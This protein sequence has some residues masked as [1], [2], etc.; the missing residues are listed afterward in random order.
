MPGPLPDLCCHLLQH[1][2]FN[3]RLPDP[4]SKQAGGLR[5]RPP[6]IDARGE[7]VAADAEPGA[8]LPRLSARLPLPRRMRLRHLK[9]TVISPSS[10]P[11]GDST[12]AN[13]S[14]RVENFSPPQLNNPAFVL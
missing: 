5:G 6:L 4:G 9:P 7:P 2:H 11:S 13:A 14:A 10:S 12:K 1:Q 8:L 3:I